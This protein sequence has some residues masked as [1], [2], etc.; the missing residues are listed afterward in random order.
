MSFAPFIIYLAI[1]VGLLFWGERLVETFIVRS[2]DEAAVPA[3]FR[4]IEEVA[5]AVLGLYFLA[6]GLA[7]LSH[8]WASVIFESM[9]AQNPV[10]D[11]LQFTPLLA[12][13]IGAAVRV[14]IGAALAAYAKRLVSFRR[15]MAFTA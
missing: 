15:R 7:D 4:P 12:G 9:R 13:I 14:L 1:G 2:S 8:W 5:I 3:D 6:E 11:V 10:V